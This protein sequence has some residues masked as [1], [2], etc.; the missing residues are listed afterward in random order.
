MVDDLSVAVHEI[1]VIGG[2][3]HVRFVQKLLD[4]AVIHVHQ[5][6][7][8]RGIS[9]SRQ[10]HR[11]T[12][13]D[14]PVIAKIDFIKKILHMRRGK[15]NIFHLPHCL[16]K[17]FLMN[18]I[19]VLLLSGHRSRRHQLTA[20]C[21]ACNADQIPLVR[22]VQKIHLL[23]QGVPGKIFVLDDTVIHGVRDTAHTPQV[24]LQ[25]NC[26]LVKN[27]LPTLAHGMLDRIY[28]AIVQRNT[29][30]S[31]TNRRNDGKRD[32]DR[33]LYRLRLSVGLKT[34]KKLPVKIF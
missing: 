8:Q 18:H 22:L 3:I 2:I 32:R 31:H 14:H 15:V 27:L 6:H 25:I 7:A 21:I 19:D 5:Q 10:L 9:V 34:G 13:G 23:I 33:H 17:P 28:K 12:K 24:R 26:R 20:V 30:R 4:A 29:K 11:L 1:D 16:F